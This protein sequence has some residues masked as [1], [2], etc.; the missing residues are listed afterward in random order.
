MNNHDAL[1]VTNTNSEKIKQLTGEQW[2]FLR[3]TS[4]APEVTAETGKATGK[5]NMT[6][7]KKEQN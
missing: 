2:D 6:Q 7:F 4:F 5:E 1:R 3:H